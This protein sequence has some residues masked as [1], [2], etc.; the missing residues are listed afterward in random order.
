VVQEKEET[1][2]EP[3]RKGI[4]HSQRV[5]IKE[6][7]FTL[8]PGV[9]GMREQNVCNSL[10]CGLYFSHSQRLSILMALI[11]PGHTDQVQYISSM[12]QRH[13]KGSAE[14]GI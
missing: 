10:S 9:S 4:S 11:R 7:N 8:F 6:K 1:L 3:Q 13:S 2:K 12:I 5:Q 14:T